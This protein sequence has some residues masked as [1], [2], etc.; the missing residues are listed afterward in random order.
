MTIFLC[1]TNILSELARPQPN[2]GV[3]AW[4][5]GLSSI[6]VSVITVEEIAY[7]LTW[8]PNL[9]I[10]EW[11]QDFL[12]NYSE[13]LPVTADIAARAGR[14]RGALQ[15]QGRTR[16]QADMLIAATAQFHGLTLVTRNAKD[17]E[18]CGLALLDPFR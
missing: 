11:F 13:V 7:G 1:D 6:A 10:L 9:R 12:D 16:A 14:L 2:A 15:A 3:E 18:D 5:Q 8:K 4:A 17:F